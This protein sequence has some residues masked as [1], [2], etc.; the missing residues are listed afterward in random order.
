VDELATAV[1]ERQ[2][3]ALIDAGLPRC[4]RRAAGRLPRKRRSGAG[5]VVS[6]MLIP[7]L[8]RSSNL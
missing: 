6:W 2:A 4:R 3:E 7:A 8:R 1:L 5:G